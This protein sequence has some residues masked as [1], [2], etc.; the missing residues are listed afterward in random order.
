[1]SPAGQRESTG[2]RIV[3][4]CSLV[5]HSGRVTIS[6]LSSHSYLYRL[7]PF[8][9]VVARESSRRKVRDNL[10]GL[11]EEA[12]DIQNV[13]P[14][15]RLGRHVRLQ[16]DQ[17]QPSLSIALPKHVPLAHGFGSARLA[18]IDPRLIVRNNH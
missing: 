18:A 12:T 14:F 4:G 15:N 7:D 9:P 8:D 13:F 11:I 5:M 1:M 17:H 6:A 10:E 3:T 16:I 2:L